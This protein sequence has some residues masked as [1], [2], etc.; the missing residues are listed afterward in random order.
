MERTENDV[1]GDVTVAYLHELDI[2]NLPTPKE[3]QTNLIYLFK[4]EFE[5]EN[6]LK[7]KIYHWKSPRELGNF[8]IAEIILKLHEVRRLLW[9]GTEQDDNCDLVVYQNSG[10]YE[11]IYVKDKLFFVRL[12]KSY[13]R[14]I[15]DKALNEIIN[16]LVHSA[17]V[18]WR[19]DDPDLTAVNNGIF[20]YKK[21]QLQP[22]S[23]DYVFTSKSAVDYNPMATSPK[24]H[25]DV[26]NTDWDVD[27]W[28]ESLSDDKEL[29]LL[30]WQV[31]G[32]TIRPHVKWNKVICFYSVQGNNGKG[33]L[34][35]LMR[36]LCGKSS[37]ASIPFADFAKEF[38]LSQLTH[39]SAVIT[40]ENDTN[41]FT[42]A[43]GS[44]KAVITG[45]PLT[46]NR[47]F[48]EPITIQFN[49]AM[50]QC[51][52][53]LPKFGDR[54]ESLYRRFLLI[55]FNKC[56][57]GQ[58]RK[59]IK[60]DYLHR[61][62]VLEY[63]L[64]KV[65]NMTYDE[66]S[67]PAVCLD[68]MAEYKVFNDPVRQFLGEILTK[69]AWDLVPYQFL[70]DLYVAWCRRNNPSGSV[71]KKSQV[72]KQVREILKKDKIWEIKDSPQP[73]RNH[74]DKPEV[75]IS[76]YNLT[77]WTNTVYKGDDYSRIGMPN[78]LSTSYTGLKR[79]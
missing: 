77:N 20:N 69:L 46:I 23:P 68:L 79:S 9:L 75:L 35:E 47:K 33:T 67:E 40:D 63:V 13:N 27:S 52:N 2:N 11:G 15:S 21:K 7:P 74:M 57:T 22:F 71:A 29:Q 16:E 70:Y 18:C 53:D 65:L 48:K 14:N 51:M 31:I 4:R 43:A 34:C 66:F 44:L 42:K 19:E 3:I 8:V 41:D 28:V 50:V 37:C 62:E 30:L 10:K 49:G 64:F 26:D 39:I 1:L 6:V 72:I 58:E 61:T 59:Y 73:T 17:P 32:S 76:E 54:S 12:I 24:I 78:N 36:N 25:N 5:V 60:D 56:F 55:P 38:M 45:D